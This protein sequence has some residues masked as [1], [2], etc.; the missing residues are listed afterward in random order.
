MGKITQPRP[1]EIGDDRHAFDCGKPSLNLWFQRHA[2]KNQKSGVSRTNVLCDA[3][4][5]NIVAFISLTTAEIQR[6]Y[7]PKS[8]QRNKPDPVPA[9]LLGQLAVDLNYQKQGLAKSLLLFAFKTALSISENIGCYCLIT[10]PVDDAA[11]SFYQYWGFEDIPYTQ[12]KTMLIRI[13]DLRQ[14]GFR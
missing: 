5:G 6:E 2:W 7:L 14:N 4:T 3:S 10:H 9:I 1:L 11:S 12:S 13:A 8:Q